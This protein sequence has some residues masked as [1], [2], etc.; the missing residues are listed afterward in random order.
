VPVKRG[1]WMPK[2]ALNML[3]VNSDSIISPGTMKLP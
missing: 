3:S 2:E 1:M